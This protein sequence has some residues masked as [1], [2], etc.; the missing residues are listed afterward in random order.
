MKK[1]HIAMLCIIA[2]L[3]LSGCNADKKDLQGLSL[4]EV[5]SSNGELLNEIRD[6]NTLYQFNNL[7]YISNLDDESEQSELKSSTDDCP[8]LYTIVSYK[9]PAAIFGDK[10][11]EKLTEITL[12]E[13]S[14]VIKEQIA[15]ENIKAAPI[16]EEF[17]T[18]YTT[19]LEDDKNFLLSLVETDN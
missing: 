10:S 8:V 19:A 14:N 11:L 3:L 12:Y 15:P 13:N 16:P 6:E 17:L 7:D 9:T 5:Y 2:L 4:I 1:I 18:F